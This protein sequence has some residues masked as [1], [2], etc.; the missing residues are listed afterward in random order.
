MGDENMNKGVCKYIL[1]NGKTCNRKTK[2]HKFICD[3]HAD[4]QEQEPYGRYCEFC[5]I[6]TFN[7]DHHKEDCETRE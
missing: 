5:G 1:S 3:E 4:E 6:D 7:V 2:T